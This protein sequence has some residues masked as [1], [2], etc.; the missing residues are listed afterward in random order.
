LGG[1]LPAKDVAHAVVAL[2]LGLEMLSHLDGD[3]EP[4]LAL[5]AHAKQLAS[6]VEGL[7]APT[8]SEESR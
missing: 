2:Y 5:F 7:T 8:T 3:A 6:L 1:V 4:A